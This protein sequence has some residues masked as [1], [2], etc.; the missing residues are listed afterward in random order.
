MTDLNY[1]D[2]NRPT[3]PCLLK[4]NDHFVWNLINTC[5]DPHTCV[6]PPTHTPVLI[7]NL[8]T[9]KMFVSSVAANVWVHHVSQKTVQTYFLSE[10]CQILTDRE[11]FWHKYSQEDKLF[12]G[13]L[14]F[15]HVCG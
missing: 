5:V 10:L 2:L 8:S 7:H 14:I 11:K 12:W 4:H 15:N 9:C 3:L 1:P 6:D 13:L